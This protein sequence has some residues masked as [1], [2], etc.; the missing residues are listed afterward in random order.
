M[1]LYLLSLGAGLLVGVI[2]GLLQIRSPAPP[3]VALVGL[4]GILLGEQ[5]VPL[6]RR[7]LAGEAPSLS[8]LREECAGHLLGPLPGR[9]TP[10]AGKPTEPA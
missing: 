1:R 2:Y 6:A 7:L 4:L 10:P 8:M 5:V 9:G 3:V